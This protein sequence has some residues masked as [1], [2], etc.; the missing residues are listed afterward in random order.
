MCYPSCH[1][2]DGRGGCQ[3][4][5]ILVIGIAIMDKVTGMVKSHNYHNNSSQ[6]VNRLNSMF[7][8]DCHALS[9][10]LPSQKMQVTKVCEKK[11]RAWRCG[12]I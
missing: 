2:E 9:N 4:E 1:E 8:V 12:D 6:Q 10:C 11:A 3:V 5:R 7:I